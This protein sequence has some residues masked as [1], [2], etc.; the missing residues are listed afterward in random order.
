MKKT[1]IL[2]ESDLIKI[3]QRVIKEQANITSSVLTP[4]VVENYFRKTVWGIIDNWTSIEDLKKLYSV[5]SPLSGKMVK[6]IS[7]CFFYSP[8]QKETKS[9]PIN[10]NALNYINSLNA[11]VIQDK[12]TPGSDY[13]PEYASLYSD[14]SMVGT[15]T[16][17]K[18][19]DLMKKKLLDLLTKNGITENS[20]YD[21]GGS[22]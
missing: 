6:G 8:D 18:E 9:K 7:K 5:L 15:K 22:K 14:I 11:N 13:G 4:D 3:V 2:T 16:L 20:V 10:T 19:G 12:C 21:P 17:G 1:V